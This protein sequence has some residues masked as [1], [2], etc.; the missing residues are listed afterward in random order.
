MQESSLS[1]SSTPFYSHRQFMKSSTETSMSLIL[2][3]TLK[4][5]IVQIT[6]CQNA[7][8]QGNPTKKARRYEAYPDN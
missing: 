3:K 2:S 4:M 7:M 6:Q 5:E 8:K 1:A